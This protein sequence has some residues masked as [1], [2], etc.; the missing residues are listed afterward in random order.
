LAHAND[1]MPPALLPN[2][3]SQNTVDQQVD[4]N[5]NN[6]TT[7]NLYNTNP[8]MSEIMHGLGQ[9]LFQGAK[10]TTQEKTYTAAQVGVEFASDGASDA[11][12]YS[13][14]FED[15]AM[16]FEEVMMKYHYNVDREMAFTDAP[17]NDGSFCDD[18]VVRWGQ[19]NRI[20]DPLVKARAQKV[21]GQLLGRTDTFVYFAILPTP[22]FMVNG[23][24]WC[25]IEVTNNGILRK[26]QLRPLNPADRLPPHQSRL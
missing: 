1:F 8:L 3:S 26:P 21:V 18:Y 9:V 25:S 23:S 15:T 14:P 10:A 2:V 20:G 11:Y 12:A 24:D 22:R 4:A 16:L 19:R 5:F 17:L 13:S 6:M 7:T